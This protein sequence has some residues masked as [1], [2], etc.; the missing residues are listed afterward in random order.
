MSFWLKNQ[1]RK[2]LVGSHISKN[3]VGALLRFNVGLF[4][5]EPFGKL[6]VWL[7]WRRLEHS[8][9]VWVLIN[10]WL[11]YTVLLVLYRLYW[12]TKMAVRTQL[13]ALWWH[14]SLN[15]FLE[16]AIP[17]IWNDGIMVSIPIHLTILFIQVSDPVQNPIT[18]ICFSMIAL[19]EM[20]SCGHM[21]WRVWDWV[22]SVRYTDTVY[23]IR[24]MED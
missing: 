8:S 23:G 4:I 15:V 9:W 14:V 5:D 18:H 22:I 11:Y 1:L 2:H 13:N 7:E 16:A 20:T 17:L 3:P 10:Y 24:Y 21:V 6:V 19:C 12:K